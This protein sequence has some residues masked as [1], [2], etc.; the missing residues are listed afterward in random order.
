M[1]LRTPPIA[2]LV[3][4]AALT[5]CSGGGTAS[6]LAP[7][8]PAGQSQ[9]HGQ[10]VIGGIGG[11]LAILLCDA[12]PRIGNITPTAIN[13]AVDS[14]AV[15]SNG[16]TV[17]I[18]QYPQPYIVNVLEQQNGNAADIGIGQ[19]FSGAYQAVQFTFDVAH[20]QVVNGS[21]NYPISFLPNNAAQ[22]SAGAGPTTTSSQPTPGKVTVTVAGN[23]SIGGDPAASIQA[24]FNALESLAFNSNGQ[25]VSRPTLFAVPA[26]QAGKVD[27][28]VTNSSGSPV[29]G[30][31]VV[32][33]DANGNVAN[34]TSTDSTGAYDL[35]TISAGN[36][37]IVVYNS[38]TTATGQTVTATGNSNAAQSVNGPSVTVNAQETTQAPVIQD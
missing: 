28:V 24:D 15:V 37:T 32:A 2:A 7:A 20:S 5:A 12:P 19:Y 11:L 18:A 17:T 14:V 33:L 27:G 25:I 1:S 23:F 16:Q 8:A 13:L 29:S 4:L 31:T 38:Y 26:S 21:T 34:T 36:Y 9:K 6:H 22:S 3:L 30:A 35:H 10:E